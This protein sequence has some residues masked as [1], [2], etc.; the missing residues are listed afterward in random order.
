MNK[1]NM[2]KYLTL[3]SEFSLANEFRIDLQLFLG[4]H[5]TVGLLPFLFK[6]ILALKVSKL[7]ALL[8]NID[9]KYFTCRVINKI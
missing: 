3:L 6:S 2:L 1:R 9:F 8:D 7:I 4:M 5:D